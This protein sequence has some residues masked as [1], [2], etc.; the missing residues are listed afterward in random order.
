MLASKPPNRLSV[1]EPSSLLLPALPQQL[2]EIDVHTTR[3]P[4][5]HPDRERRG[6]YRATLREAVCERRRPD[7]EDIE[8]ERLDREC[9]VT[10]SCEERDIVIERN[11]DRD[12]YGQSG[13]AWCH[14]AQG[15]AERTTQA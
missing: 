14:G 10:A 7:R 12:E 6:I 9:D 2:L 1:S 3:I 5:I 11:E 13:G 4:K 15:S 8:T